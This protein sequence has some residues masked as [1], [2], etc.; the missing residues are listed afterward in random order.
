MSELSKRFNKS[1]R[2]VATKLREYKNKP[3]KIKPRE[4]VLVIDAFY[5]GSLGVLVFRDPHKG[6][7][8]HWRELLNKES[9]SDYL[10]GIKHL[11]DKGF[12]IKAI[13]IDGKPGVK[14]AV[15]SLFGIPVQM[16]QF[17]QVQ[18]VTRYLTRRPK[19]QASKELRSIALKLKDS[20]EKE[21]KEELYKWHKKWKDFLNEKTINPETGRSHYT[22]KRLRSAYFSLKRNL[23]NLFVFE[24]YPSLNIPK[25]TNAL[26]AIFSHIKTPLRIHRGLSYE[27]KKKLIGF[28]LRRF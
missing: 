7:N 10:S 18:I 2:W 3:L 15:E 1:K 25:T 26:E 4:V 14:Q 6:E 12:C 23:D 19:L 21:F 9:V 22:H 27:N 13:T 5:H 17:H 20:K 24:K 8:L 28:L 16:C 11:Q